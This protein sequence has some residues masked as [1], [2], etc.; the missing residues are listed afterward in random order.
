MGCA[1]RRGEIEVGVEEWG[2]LVSVVLAG[3]WSGLLAMPTVILHPVLAATD[4]RRFAEFLQAFL[5]VAEHSPLNLVA[6]VGLVVFPAIGVATLIDD[7]GAGLVLV[8]IGLVLTVAGPL[9]SSRYL[10][11][12]NYAVIRAWNPA[13]LPADWEPIRRRYF[14]LNWLRA[15]PTWAAFGLFL[16]ALVVL[17]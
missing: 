7:R 3:L 17:L 5:P 10:A 9:L 12:P 16:A 15:F 8:A 11:E 6:V 14:A 2:V 4:G 1:Q 13:A